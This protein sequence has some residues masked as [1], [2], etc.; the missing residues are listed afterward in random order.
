MSEARCRYHVTLILLSFHWLPI[1]QRIVF[2]T[3]PSAGGVAVESVHNPMSSTATVCIDWMH[4]AIHEP[5]SGL[6]AC[7]MGQFAIATSR[8]PF[9]WPGFFKKLSAS[10]FKISFHFA[11]NNVARTV[12]VLSA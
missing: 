12:H 7:S 8:A 6:W 1:W 11:N 3:A 9:A 4:P 5:D 10:A 2:K